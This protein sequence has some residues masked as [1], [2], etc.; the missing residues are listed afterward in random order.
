MDTG[1]G[2]LSTQAQWVELQLVKPATILNTMEML[3]RQPLLPAF[4]TTLQKITKPDMFQ[5]K[6][7]AKPTRDKFQVK[8]NTIAQK[9]LTSRRIQTTTKQLATPNAFRCPKAAIMT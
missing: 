3:P 8:T 6:H 2:K 4:T 7:T 1:G 9:K 5:R